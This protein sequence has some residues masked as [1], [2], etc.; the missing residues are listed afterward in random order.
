MAVDVSAPL[1]ELELAAA[2]IVRVDTGDAAAI[3]TR[4]VVHVSQD[5]PELVNDAPLT[6]P[7]LAHEQLGGIEAPGLSP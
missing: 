6:P 2:A 4:L 5:A 7:L 3:I 1:P